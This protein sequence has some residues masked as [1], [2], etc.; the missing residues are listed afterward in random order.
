[1]SYSSSNLGSKSYYL[2]FTDKYLVLRGR[3][4]GS[5]WLRGPLVLR[6]GL[7]LEFTSVSAFPGGQQLEIRAVC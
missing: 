3:E 7:E 5:N 4:D 2:S 1:M 6:S